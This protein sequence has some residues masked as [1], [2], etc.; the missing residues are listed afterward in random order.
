MGKNSLLVEISAQDKSALKEIKAL[1]GELK[2]LDSVYKTTA[3]TMRMQENA[4]GTLQNSQAH[5]SDKLKVVNDKIKIASEQHKALSEKLSLQKKNVDLTKQSLDAYNKILKDSEKVVEK[6]KEALSNAKKEYINTGK[7]YRNQVAEIKNSKKNYDELNASIEN[8]KQRI[9]TLRESKNH[10]RA[11]IKKEQQLMKEEIAQRDLLAKSIEKQELGLA[12]IKDAML[13]QKEAIKDRNKEL[14]ESKEAYDRALESKKKQEAE[15]IKE[16]GKYKKIEKVVNQYANALQLAQAQRDNLTAAEQKAQKEYAKAVIEKEIKKLKEYSDTLQKT[17]SKYKMAGDTLNS[18]GNGILK[19]T[20]PLVAVGGYGIKSAIEFESAFAGVKKTVDATDLQFAKLRDTVLSMSERLPQSAS[21]ISQI[22]EVAGQLGIGVN[23]LAK[24]SEVMVKLGDSTNVA[25]AEAALLLAQ[26]MNISRTAP[27]NVDRLGSVIVDLGNKTATTEDKIVHMMHSLA[28]GGSIFGLTE[29]EIAGLSATLSATGIEAEKGGTA[30]TKFMFKL[31]GVAS[32]SSEEFKAMGKQL[33]MTVEEIDEMMETASSDLENFAKVV[34]LTGDEFRKLV[35]ESPAEA[36]QKVI[37]GFGEMADRGEDIL[38]VLEA[39]GIKEVRLRDTVLRLAK[40]HKDLGKNLDISRKA[41]QENTALTVEANKRY[42]TTESKLKMLKNQFQNLSIEIGVE[43]LPT[44][45]NLMKSGKDFISYIKNLDEG[46]K[47]NIITFTKWA[48]ILGASSKGLGFVSNKVAS[49]LEF[50]KKINDLRIDKLSAM[51]QGAESLA[52]GFDAVSKGSAVASSKMGLFAK[53]IGLTNP[54]VLG[55]VAGF[56]TL[57]GAV[58]VYNTSQSINKKT[59]LDS[60]ESYTFLENAVADFRGVQRLTKKELEDMGLVY[61]DTSS[62]SKGFAEAVGL[63]RKEVADFNWDLQQFTLDGFLNE[64]E[65]NKVSTQV[66]NMVNSAKRVLDTNKD[67]I[68]SKFSKLFSLDGVIDESEKKSLKIMTDRIDGE[69]KEIDT[70]YAEIRTILQKHIDEKRPIYEQ[71]KKDVEEKVK[72]IKEIELQGLTKTNEDVLY[73]KNKFKNEIGKLDLNGASEKLQALRTQSQAEIAEIN[74][75]FDT[76]I[77]ITRDKL[78]TVSGEEKSALQ[79]HLN[80]LQ[81]KKNEAVGIHKGQ[82]QDMLNVIKE[83]YPEMA[84]SIDI[85]TGKMK[86][87]DDKRFAD[88]LAKFKKHYSDLNFITKTGWANIYDEQ[89]NTMRMMYVA[90]DELTGEITG[91]YDGTTK[92]IIASSQE[93]EKAFNDLTNT[94][95]FSR[96]KMTASFLSIT[97]HLT[98]ST[99]LNALQLNDLKKEFGFVENAVGELEG[100]IKDLNGNVVKV[101]VEKDNTIKNIEEIKKKLSSINRNIDVNVNV[102]YSSSGSMKHPSYRGFAK[103]EASGTNYLR[104]FA[105]GINYLPSFAGGGHVRSRVN[106]LGFE[107]FDL[108]KN[109]KAFMIGTNRGDDIMDLP[110]GTKITNHIASTKLMIEA[111][112]KEVGRRMTPVY[113]ALSQN[114][115]VEK[116]EIIQNV[117]VRFEKVTIYDERDVTEIMEQMKYEIMKGANTTNEEY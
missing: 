10:S 48:L 82:Y 66:Q 36:L 117:N 78:Q 67:E 90:V 13:K 38:P 54:V 95:D 72:R 113:D 75:R 45:L 114:R 73:M 32:K 101:K 80:T 88:E 76:E 2:R 17:I 7:E 14:K 81:K 109:S 91:V 57:A 71:E 51:K 60:A 41:W 115:A 18:V 68:S 42:E 5:Y 112:K 64:E 94:I 19:M 74:A 97:S 102:N 23:D 93:Q 63:A 104:G 39:L 111:I 108:P 34:G 83:K 89:T 85:T 100:E 65:T 11:D 16:E 53:S 21:E 29:A 46:T 4:F 77:Q 98:N 31:K 49:F 22:M 79:E 43:L 52:G 12:K 110:V 9:K 47:Q 28:G 96:G 61:S 50:V 33:G 103:P 84:K 70:L 20:A 24:F 59:V 99:K 30:M 44:L 62:L 56:T 6:N 92:K 35:K 86:V 105:G 27:E 87:K 58:A 25:S 37:E 40:G 116:K 69:K 107:L 55:L 15:L 8:H 1:N 3:E 106:E 26:F